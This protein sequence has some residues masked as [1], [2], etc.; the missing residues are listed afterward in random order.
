MQKHLVEALYSVSY[1]VVA[2]KHNISHQ[3]KKFKDHMLPT[4]F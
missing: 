4:N 2:E 1:I 3:A